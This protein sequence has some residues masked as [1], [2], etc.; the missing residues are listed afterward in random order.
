MSMYRGYIVDTGLIAVSA[1]SV[2]LLYL[3]PTSSNDANIVKIKFA[4]SGSSGAA[5]ASNADIVG[6]FNIVTGTVGGNT[7]VTPRQVSGNTLA[8]NTVCD[9]ATAST[10][11]TGLT[12]GNLLWVG[13]VPQT[14]GATWADDDPNTGIEIALLP[15]T[16]YAFYA[17]SAAGAGTDMNVRFTVWFAE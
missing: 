10:G 14:S 3:A 2:P 6:L 17:G 8:A 13:D 7:A 16:K 9:F 12:A 4:V 11:L 15:S 1:S 5:P